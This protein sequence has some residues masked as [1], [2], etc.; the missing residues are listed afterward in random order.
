MD[1]ANDFLKDITGIVTLLIGVALIALLVGHANATGSLITAST[2]GLNTL[3]NT[4]ELTSTASN[5]AYNG[6]GGESGEGLGGGSLTNL[7]GSIGGSMQA[8]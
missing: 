1:T 2:S 7:F 5:T 4:V 3:L 8:L 6:G